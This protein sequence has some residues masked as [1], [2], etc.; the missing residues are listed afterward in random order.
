MT[1]RNALDA[2]ADARGPIAMLVCALLGI[3]LVP[4]LTRTFIDHPPLY[5]EL[6]HLLAARGVLATG[7]PAI[8][9]GIYGRA[10]LFTRIVATSLSQFGDSPVAARLPALAAAM[11]LVG[12]VGAWTCRRGGFLAGIVT[13]GLLA[14]APST[15]SLAA[16][17]R[18]YTLHALLIVAMLIAVFEALEPT[19]R[20]PAAIALLAVAAVF[21]PIALHL[22]E[23]TVISA[24]AGTLAALS[25]LAFDHRATLWPWVTRRPLIVIAGLAGACTVGLLLVWQLGLIERLGTAPLWAAERAGRTGYYNTVLIR[26]YPLLWPLLPLAIAA[27][28][29]RHRRLALY[30]TVI[31]VSA[32]VVHS[33][34]AQK[35]IRYYYHVLPFVCVLWGIGIANAAKLLQ[36]GIEYT[37][38]RLA[39]IALIVSVAFLGFTLANSTEGQRGARLLLARGTTDDSITNA[40]EAEWG[41]ALPAL[42]DYVNSA[43]NVV[44]SSSVKSLFAFGR[45]DYELNASVVFETETGQEFGR[46]PRTGRQAIG[47]RASIERL[48]N[49]AGTTLVVIEDEKLDDDDGAPADTV[50]LVR[51]RCTEI[52]VPPESQL[53]AWFCRD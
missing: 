46:D 33:I 21:L 35:A 25:L 26:N 7:E 53:N 40:S 20:R 8:D 34:A 52:E 51:Q 27:T 2:V 42:R 38:P 6:L 47:A 12:L 18:F 24:G 15:L 28:A 22:Q 43:D 45:Y 49:E 39:P 32:L 4:V 11:A 48:L 10:E 1:D 14:T 30:S 44:A 29:I 19:H 13:T 37:I 9:S 41:I 17:A 3:L 36:Q 23:T 50:N 16:F 5:D 31:I